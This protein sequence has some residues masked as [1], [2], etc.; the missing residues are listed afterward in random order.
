MQR[1][2]SGTCRPDWQQTVHDQGL[3]YWQT[4]L[5]GTNGETRSYWRE[6]QFY[7]FSQAEVDQ[8]YADSR[9]IFQMLCDAGDYL[10]ARPELMCKLGI[11]DFAHDQVIA[12]WNRD[13]EYGVDWGS[14]YGRYDVR[15]GGN[16]LLDPYSTAVQ[17]DDSLGRIKLY[18]F[19]ADTPT[20]LL[21]SAMIQWYWYQ[22]TKQGQDQWNRIYEE[23]VDAWKRSLKEIE[24][25]LGHKPTVHF[26]CSNYDDSGE[27][28]K[29]TEV[30]ERACEA[31]GY[32]TRP[33]FVEDVYYNE[34]DGRF[35]EREGGPHIDVAFKLH[36]WEHIVQG[37]HGELFFKDMAR[38]GERS[39]DGST[40]IGGTIWIEPPYKML[41][42]NKGILAVLWTLFGDDPEKSQ[43][44]LPTYFEEEIPADFK[45]FVQKPL[46]SREGANITH[47]R[48][49]LEVMRTSGT[50]GAEG[51]V[52]QQYAPPPAFMSPDGLM[53]P[54][55]GIW[56]IDGEPSGMGIRESEGVITDNLSFFAPHVIDY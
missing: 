4:T 56:M 12:T 38:V 11:P 6:D 29:N 17:A 46:L 8:I 41:W 23:L 32:Q 40:Y 7:A 52:Y 35:Y 47:L 54:V 19:N 39:A 26:M 13:V 5:P 22:D 27:D 10:V 51:F 55:L 43:L 36:P 3:V 9:T 2:S 16:L 53:H 45:D 49:G 24:A 14:V 1:I 25:V 18:E 20:A 15:Y 28:I 21:E 30:L 50:Y 34:L 33:M 37:T 42:S 48:N 44:L 31:A